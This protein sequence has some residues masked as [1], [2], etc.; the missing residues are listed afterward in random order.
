LAKLGVAVHVR[1]HVFHLAPYQ[2]ASAA[3]FLKAVLLKKAN[4]QPF[5]MRGLRV[6]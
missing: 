3:L 2:H 1:G 6:Q 5:W 4:I